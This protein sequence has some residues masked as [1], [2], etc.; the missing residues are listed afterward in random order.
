[1]LMSPKPKSAVANMGHQIEIDGCRNMVSKGGREMRGGLI[2]SLHSSSN[3]TIRVRPGAPILRL[4]WHTRVLF[5]AGQRWPT[6]S[7]LFVSPYPFS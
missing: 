2:G 3:P 6:D 7:P 5:R 4:A 1:M